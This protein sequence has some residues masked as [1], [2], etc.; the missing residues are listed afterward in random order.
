[1]FGADLSTASFAGQYDTFLHLTTLDEVLDAVRRCWASQYEGNVFHYTQKMG[2]KHSVGMAVV[3][4]VGFRIS[5]CY[6]SIVCR[7]KSTLQ[8][9][10]LFSLAILLASEKI[11]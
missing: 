8:L 4:Q 3:V 6:F 5:V 2:L 11:S 10:E 1:M 7:F 9:R